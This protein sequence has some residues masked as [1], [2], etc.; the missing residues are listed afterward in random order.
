M[1]VL[2]CPVSNHTC[3]CNCQIDSWHFD[4]FY[5]IISRVGKGATSTVYRGFDL[6]N[7]SPI[8]I[9][10]IPKCKLTSSTHIEYLKSEISILS[11]MSHKNIIQLVDE[12]EDPHFVYIITEFCEKGSL[13][14]FM[15][16]HKNGIPVYSALLILQQILF[17]LQH[18]H[19]KWISHRDLKP[20]N[21]LL[22]AN[23]IVKLADFGRSIQMEKATVK[24]VARLVGTLEYC[25]PE[26]IQRKKCLLDPRKN[27][28]WAC[29]VIFYEML[30]GHPLFYGRNASE[31]II[32]IINCN[33]KELLRSKQL[34]FLPQEVKAILFGML[35]KTVRIRIN[36][37]EA[38]EMVK[39]AILRYRV[40]HHKLGLCSYHAPFP[41]DL[42]RTVSEPVTNVKIV[43]EDSSAGK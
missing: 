35:Q 37:N 26:L 36:V 33:A 6:L 21:I 25:S 42:R 29:G 17:G 28:M 16:S 3:A 43:K 14:N 13:Q 24:Q 11:K 34:C 9:K 2:G 27:D 4:K 10:V 30:T 38:L 31:V 8:A 18:I 15:R 5:K 40:D 41:K 12:K 20:G 23:G 19:E 32:R 39:T 7:D 22:T 1:R